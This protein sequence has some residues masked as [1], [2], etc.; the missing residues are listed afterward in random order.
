[1]S[2]KKKSPLLKGGGPPGEARGWRDSVPLGFTRDW[3]PPATFGGPPPF[4][5]GGF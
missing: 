4:D 3:N 5:K 1:M 2:L